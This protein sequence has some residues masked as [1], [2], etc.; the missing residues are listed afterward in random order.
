MYKVDTGDP[1]NMLFY[2]KDL[3]RELKNIN[4]S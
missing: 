3:V 2:L 4:N 1:K